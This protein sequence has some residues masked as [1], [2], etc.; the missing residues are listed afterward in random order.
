MNTSHE[1]THYRQLGQRVWDAVGTSFRDGE[2]T[3]RDAR[4]NLNAPEIHKRPLYLSGGIESN[5]YALWREHSDDKPAKVLGTC[6]PDYTHINTSDICRIW[7][8]TIKRPVRTIGTL[9]NGGVMFIVTELPHFRVKERDTVVNDFVLYV[10]M[11]GAGA[12]EGWNTSVRLECTNMM[13]AQRKKA[14]ES[15]KIA[16]TGDVERLLTA[17]MTGLYD[18]A[19]SRSQALEQAYNNMVDYTLK[20]DHALEFFNAVYPLP[21][22]PRGFS[23]IDPGMR[24]TID[25]ESDGSFVPEIVLAQNMKSYNA[26][27]SFVERAHEY[28][29]NAFFNQAVRGQDTDT[30]RGTLFGALNAVT[31]FETHRRA[32]GNSNIEQLMIG[33]RAKTISRAHGVA[34]DII[35]PV[36]A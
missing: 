10:P 3:A 36:Q 17:W 28:V 2:S 19:V 9:R 32:R 31:S 26:S 27:L 33:Q 6:G 23:H 25:T 12:I 13:R 20:P 16:H 30:T 29:S 7:D 34:M 21:E 15:F 14:V 11:N 8:E 4:K 18:R 5:V 35:E 22:P 24:I 1:T